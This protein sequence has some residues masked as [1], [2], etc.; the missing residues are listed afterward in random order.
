[1]VAMPSARLRESVDDHGRRHRHPP[2]GGWRAEEWHSPEY[3]L[4]CGW[5][6]MDSEMFVVVVGQ[7][8][9]D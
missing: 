5:I 4:V 3:F 7:R 1:M 6:K 8:V 9:G 2:I